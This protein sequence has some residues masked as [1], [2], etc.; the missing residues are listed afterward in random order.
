[1]NER[2]QN[3]L[4]EAGGELGGEHPT[5][6]QLVIYTDEVDYEKFAQLIVRECVNEIHGAYVGNLQAKAWYLDRVA[7][8][9]E[10]HF[11]IEQ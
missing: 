4:L 6:G 11:G 1:M 3:L 5:T 2:I 8:H 9:V 7:E 10:K